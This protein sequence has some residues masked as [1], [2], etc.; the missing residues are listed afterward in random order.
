MRPLAPPP[1]QNAESYLLYTKIG[2][3]STN[4]EKNL[5]EKRCLFNFFS[6]H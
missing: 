6:E 3:K 1:K 2:A 5:Q 4:I